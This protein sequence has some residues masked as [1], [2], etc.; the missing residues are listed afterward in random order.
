MSTKIK[1]HGAAGHGKFMHLEVN[2]GASG[3]M[4][5]GTHEF[6]IGQQESLVQY[7]AIRRLGTGKIQVLAE[8]GDI[9]VEVDG[10]KSKH[11]RKGKVLT[12]SS[13]AKHA[14][15]RERPHR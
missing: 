8:T 13:H 6:T 1:V 10:G 14:S 5:D 15:V 2:G 11:I 3:E 4:G 9:Y 12:L 7:L